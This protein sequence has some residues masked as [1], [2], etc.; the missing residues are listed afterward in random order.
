LTFL[1]DEEPDG[2][3]LEG[4]GHLSALLQIR[5]EL[6]EGDLRSLYLGWLMGV[7]SGELKA[8]EK[9]PPVPP[10]LQDLSGPQANLADFL[11]LDADLLAAAA[12]NSPRAKV[13]AAN[14]QELASWIASLPVSEKDEILVR[15][16]AGEEVR[17]GMELKSRFRRKCDPKNCD[18]VVKA[19]TV[20]ELL[21][22]ADALK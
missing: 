3:W 19:R 16:I 21:A 14:R 22:A 9:E 13:E 18:A 17:L 8:S 5:N 6:A 15:L 1:C 7:Q 4:E 11:R 2:E 10:N 20:S 12:R